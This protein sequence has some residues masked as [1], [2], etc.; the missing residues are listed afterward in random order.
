M[1]GLIND[2]WTELAGAG[3]FRPEVTLPLG[4][5]VLVLAWGIG[6]GRLAMIKIGLEDIRQLHTDDLKLLAEKWGV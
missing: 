4:I 2:K 3:I 5:D 6:I 1:L